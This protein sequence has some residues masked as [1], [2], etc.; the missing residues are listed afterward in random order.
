MECAGYLYFTNDI[1]ILVNTAGNCLD[2]IEY[3]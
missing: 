2:R 3:P 1:L